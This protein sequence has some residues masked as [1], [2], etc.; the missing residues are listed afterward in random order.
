MADFNNAIMTD[1]GAALLAKDTA[2]VARIK[3]TKLVTGS[4]VYAESEK[5]RENLQSCTGLKEPK[6]EIPFSSISMETDTCV[7]LVALI[8]NAELTTGYYVNEV[9]V[10]AVDEM[11]EDAEPV[12]Y[13]IAVANIA[14]YLPPYNGLV[15]STITQEYFA[16]VDNALEVTIQTNAGAVA[17]AEDLEALKQEVDGKQDAVKGKGLSTEDYTTDEKQK[18][19][20]I[21]K[22]ANKTII[23]TEL[24]PESENP[25][26]NKAVDA[27]IK[28][29][30]AAVII[31]DTAPDRTENVLWVKPGGST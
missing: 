16:T 8:S 4:G 9:G 2:G 23:D 31:S 29:L 11:N 14:D 18:L 30:G 24:S 15:T 20:G 26:Q 27:A 19:A 17:L 28:S 7:K 5:A 13:S 10:Y 22:G 6:Q 1:S 12:L 25:V 3:F 21:D